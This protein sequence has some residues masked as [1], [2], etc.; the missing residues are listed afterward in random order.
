[1]YENEEYEYKPEKASAETT[2]T[3]LEE[4]LSDKPLYSLVNI[5]NTDNSLEST[6]NPFLNPA[7]EKYYRQLYESTKYECLERFDTSFEWTKKEE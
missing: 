2:V 6:E 7:V 1:M 4:S 3:Q 5:P